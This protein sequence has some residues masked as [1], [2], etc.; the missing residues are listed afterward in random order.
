MFNPKAAFP[1]AQ[2]LRSPE[3]APLGELFAFVSG[4][5]FRGKMTY[6][7][8]FGSAPEGLSGALVISPAE[9][10]RFLHERLTVPRLRAWA[11]V[12]IDEH[13]P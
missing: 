10:L 12:D 6:A 9:G 13:N 3:G 8:T 2:A 1:L 4:L 7:K 5:Y 11:E